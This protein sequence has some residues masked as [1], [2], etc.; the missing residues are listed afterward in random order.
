MKP[1]KRK[2]T[3][4]TKNIDAINRYL[5]NVADIWSIYS[6][7]YEKATAKVKD[8][9]IRT[10]KN[11]VI[12]IKNTKE[13]RKKHQ[14]IRALRNTTKSKNIIQ[15]K[16]NKRTKGLTKKDIRAIKTFEDDYSNAYKKLKELQE[17]YELDITSYLDRLRNGDT[18]SSIINDAML[19][20]EI[21]QLNDAPELSMRNTI[22]TDYGIIDADTGEMIYEF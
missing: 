1:K 22:E 21:Q 3:A 6:N 13:N 19:E 16:Y 10:N 15:R 20:S 18:P 11:G 7:E 2:R 8:F 4:T 14:K 17:K 5:Q 9:D 12:Q